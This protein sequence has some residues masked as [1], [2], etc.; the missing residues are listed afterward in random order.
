MT[1]LQNLLIELNILIEAALAVMVT[2]KDRNITSVNQKFIDIF[3]LTEPNSQAKKL[4]FL[5][6]E[7]K[8]YTCSKRWLIESKKKERCFFQRIKF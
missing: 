4:D 2:D 5:I 6:D 1:D 7:S 3:V 8:R